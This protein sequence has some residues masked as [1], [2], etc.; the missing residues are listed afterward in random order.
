MNKKETEVELKY[1][2]KDKEKLLK[3]LK[4]NAKF[5][6]EKKQVDEYFTPAHRNFFDKK[7]PVEYLRI[8]KTGEKYSTAYKHWYAMEG[9]REHSHCDEYE[10]D[11][12]DGEQL[13]KILMALDFKTLVVVDKHRIAFEYNDFE[14]TIDD[15]KQVG[16]VCEIEMNDGYNDVFDAHK[17]IKELAKKLDFSEKDRGEDLKLGYAFLIAKKNG[18]VK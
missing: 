5:L 3:W 1:A 17:K 2:I 6:Y 10:T 8:R 4:K 13:R 15:V 18:L 14:I 7:A 12:E 9:A 11:V 16:V